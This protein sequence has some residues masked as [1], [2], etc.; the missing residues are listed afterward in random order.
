M[1]T[2]YMCFTPDAR[3]TE[4]S[5]SVPAGTEFQHDH[6][7]EARGIYFSLGPCALAFGPV[8]SYIKFEYTPYS[9]RSYLEHVLVVI[10]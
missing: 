5:N 6:E 10:G 8:F 3:G 4:Y 1:V 7:C 9:P 2:I